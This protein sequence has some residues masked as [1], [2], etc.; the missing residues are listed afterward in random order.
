MLALNHVVQKFSDDVCAGR[1]LIAKKLCTSKVHF[2]IVLQVAK[3]WSLI[4]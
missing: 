4:T 2:H 1:L 3:S